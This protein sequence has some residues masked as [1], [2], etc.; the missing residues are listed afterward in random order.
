[1]TDAESEPLGPRVTRPETPNPKRQAS[2]KAHWI[3]GPI[4]LYRDDVDWIVDL[5]Q[6]HGGGVELQTGDWTCYTVDQFFEKVDGAYA[7]H[8]QIWGRGAKVTVDLGAE[9]GHFVIMRD[10]S[11]PASVGLA[12]LISERI[13]ARRMWTRV[14]QSASVTGVAVVALVASLSG[15]TKTWPPEWRVGFLALVLSILVLAVASIVNGLNPVRIYRVRSHER[16][17]WVQRHGSEI[18]I[19]LFLVIVG[20]ILGAAL[21]TAWA[22]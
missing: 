11:D 1:M 9:F 5:L 17:S 16:L 13:R 14:A 19:G 21:T 12:G 20:A 2:G 7:K 8:L 22:K 4:R 10:Q 3:R 18:A 15:V 6:E